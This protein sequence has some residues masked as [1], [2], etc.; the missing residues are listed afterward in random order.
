MVDTPTTAGVKTAYIGNL[1]L[2][3]KGKSSR[4]RT[5]SARRAGC[6][7]VALTLRGPGACA[8]GPR[9]G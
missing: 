1:T 6:G 9:L 2:K 3:G 7:A 8:P 4:A 5:A